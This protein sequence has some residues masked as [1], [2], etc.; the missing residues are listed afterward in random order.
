MRQILTIFAKDARR[1][2]PETAISWAL[3]LALV[4]VYPNQWHQSAPI[5][6]A[7]FGWFNV[8]GGAAGFSASCLVVLVP[9]SWWILIVR[10]IHCERLV[11]DTQFWITRPYEWPKLLAAKLLFLAAFLYAPF[12]AAQCVL[13]REGGF[14]PLHYGP[15]LLLNLFFLT[16]AFVLPLVALSALTTGFGRMTLLLLGILLFIVGAAIVSAYLPSATSDSIPDIISGALAFAVLLCGCVAIL[17]VQYARR[18]V[19][20][21][22]F[23]LVAVAA[24]VCAI[25]LGNPD[26]AFMNRHFPATGSTPVQLVYAAS[27]MSQPVTFQTKSKNMLFIAI[28]L[29]ESGVAEG[30]A[31]IPV[32]L[33]AE[34]EAPDGAHWQSSWQGIGSER[35]LPGASD[36]T[37]RFAIPHAIYS[38]FKP[39]PVTL[40]LTFALVEARREFA[41]VV[42]LPRGDFSVPGFGVCKPVSFLFDLDDYST[43]ACRSAMSPPQLTYIS[44]QWSDGHCS[45]PSSEPSA[46]LLG[47]GWAGEID[48][49]AAEFGITS[50]WETDV[51]LSNAWMSYHEGESARPR[52]LCPGSPVSFTQFRERA[53]TRMDLVIPKFRLPE[54]SLG[55]RFMLI[56]H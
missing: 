11:G 27:T 18:S 55:D 16:V 46:R 17:V 35:F 20:L 4:L 53:R 14:H 31:V 1:F 25:A 19:R 37:M 33:R 5:A 50:V 38:R 7:H 36:S 42:A 43:I 47:T 2:W 51:N 12:F 21:A 54:L 39:V 34:V 41:T 3:L 10:L 28:P 13:L 8:S 9:L 48:P 45:D 29:H 56:T 40:R 23:L 22:S 15:G 32:A 44:A 49:G 30:E 24:G 26:Q 52:S 6:S